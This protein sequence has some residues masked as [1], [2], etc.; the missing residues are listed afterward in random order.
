MPASPARSSG[1]RAITP[2]SVLA[3]MCLAAL[4]MLAGAC[5][6]LPRSEP[7]DEAEVAAVRAALDESAFPRTDKYGVPVDTLDRRVLVR[8]LKRSQY[9]SL[10]AELGARWRATQ[11][12][13]RNEMLLYNAYESFFQNG[14]AGL[15]PH[16]T[17]WVEARPGDAEPLLAE[18]YYRYGRA[19]EARG[20]RSARGTS[21]EEMASMMEQ[22][23]AGRAAADRAL[24]AAPG[25]V[26][27]HFVRLNLMRLGSVPDRETAINTVQAALGDNPAS[28]L[29]RDEIMLMLQPRWGGSIEMMRAFAEASR[30]FV[31][32]NPKLA[33][34]PGRVPMEEARMTKEYEMALAL[35]DQASFHGEDYHLALAYTNLHDRN[36]QP[37]E[38]L[39]ASQRARSYL[40]QGRS[41][42]ATRGQVL[43]RVAML[44]RRSPLRDSLFDMS[45]RAIALA[46]QLSTPNE[47]PARQL[48]TWK[49]TRQHCEMKDPEPCGGVF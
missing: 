23:A 46:T 12:D 38:A 21:E 19:Y 4:P 25:H 39:E 27:A 14:A 20:T 15:Q 37:V 29:L 40:P 3:M 36:N 41:H 8:W 47:D 35:L 43:L 30:E 32:T 49:L 17:R 28:F 26:I 34:L 44:M 13:I 6:L 5:G 10:A 2:S 16:L 9:D 7:V 18:A 33:L 1:S 31:G 42:V 24:Q 45:G 48:E 22:I 11:Q